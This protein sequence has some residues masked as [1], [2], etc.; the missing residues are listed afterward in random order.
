MEPPTGDTFQIGHTLPPHPQAK[1][2]YCF[3]LDNRNKRGLALDLTS[4][5]AHPVL[6]R[7]VQGA[8]GHNGNTPP[9][10]RTR[11]KLSSEVVAA[12]KPRVVYGD[13]T[14][15]GDDGPDADLP[16]FDFTAYWARSGLLAMTRDAGEPPTFPVAGS[17]DQCDGRWL[18]FRDRHGG[19]YQPRADREGLL[20]H[21]LVACRRRLGHWHDEL[22]A[23]ALRR[24]VLPAA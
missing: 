18:V 24:P 4:P 14:G 11:L 3:H 8:A 15:Y 9:P 22:Q 13:I 16:G 20:C 1:D 21:H 23:A 2:N 10:A 5:D 19:L 17:G 7:H 12:W 6:E